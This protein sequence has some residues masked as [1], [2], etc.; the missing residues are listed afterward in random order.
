[1]K[2]RIAEETVLFISILKWFILATLIGI[3]VGFATMIFLKLLSW[4]LAFSEKCR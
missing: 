4:G 2:R 3:I 1:M